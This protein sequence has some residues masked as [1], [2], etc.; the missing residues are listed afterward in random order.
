MSCQ[1]LVTRENMPRKDVVPKE[2]NLPV[3]SIAF[4][5]TN[6]NSVHTEEKRQNPL[7]DF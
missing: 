2:I 5:K 3:I 7:E 4:S 1:N 6:T